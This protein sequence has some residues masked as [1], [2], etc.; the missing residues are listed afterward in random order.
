[1]VAVSVA[2]RVLVLEVPDVEDSLDR[3]VTTGEL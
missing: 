2:Q 1:M 3:L